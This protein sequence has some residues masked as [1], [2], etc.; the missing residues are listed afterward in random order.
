MYVPAPFAVEE[1]T[2]WRI[3][4]ATGAG[5]LVV[6]TAGGLR[7]VVL[8]L[9]VKDDE[10]RLV[11]HIARAN[12]LS[13]E[14]ADGDECLVSFVAAGA[15]VSPS[16][17]PTRAQDPRVV[18]TWDFVAVEIL[19]TLGVHDDPEWAGG[20]AAELTEL[21]ESARGAPWR[22]EESPAD[23]VSRLARSVVGLDIRVREITG[24][25]KL[26]QNRPAADRASVREALAAGDAGER[27]VA[28]W[29]EVLG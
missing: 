6:A 12:P 13:R 16:L 11:G 23:H 26:S 25:A 3:A 7:S 15:Y 9:I 14:A 5:T 17:Y 19:G 20:A 2:A 21:M 10:R 4:A 29:M 18:P 1:T 27:S 8:P 22:L 28:A 24:K